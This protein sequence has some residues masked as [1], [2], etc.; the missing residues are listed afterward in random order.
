VVAREI[1]R[2]AAADGVTSPPLTICWCCDRL[3]SVDTP[4][5]GDLAVCMWCGAIAILTDDLGT[6][7]P[8]EDE[9]AVIASDEALR[10]KYMALLRR[11]AQTRHED[12]QG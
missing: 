6:A 12:Q 9:I 3:L 10:G 4:R 8:S 11:A 1:D 2:T 5:P 7:Q